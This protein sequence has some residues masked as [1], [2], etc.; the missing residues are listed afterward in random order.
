MVTAIIIVWAVA[1]L[2][3]LSAHWL[4]EGSLSSSPTRV[5]WFE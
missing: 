5:E 1:L 2:Y 3:R 4:F